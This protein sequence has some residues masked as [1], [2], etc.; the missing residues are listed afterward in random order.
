MERLRL[1]A[2]IP[3]GAADDAVDFELKLSDF[4][5]E[6]VVLLSNFSKEHPEKISFFG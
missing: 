1:L 6:R 2:F 3:F 4:F 5:A